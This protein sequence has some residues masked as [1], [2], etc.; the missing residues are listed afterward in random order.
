MAIENVGPGGVSRSGGV[1][2]PTPVNV[3]KDVAGVD[4]NGGI[5]YEDGEKVY[6]GDIP[7]YTTESSWRNMMGNTSFGRD[8]QGGAVQA[9]PKCVIP[10]YCDIPAGTKVVFGFFA[11]ASN[12]ETGSLNGATWQVGVQLAGE[13]ATFSPAYAIPEGTPVLSSTPYDGV[14]VTTTL[15]KTWSSSN[16]DG[17]FVWT[18]PADIKA[19]SFLEMY[20]WCKNG[21]MRTSSN[22]IEFKNRIPFGSYV[23]EGFAYDAN[24]ANYNN[25]TMALFT[26]GSI[27]GMTQSARES[28]TNSM[29]NG[30]AG[31]FSPAGRE[32]WHVAPSYMLVF[33]NK[34]APAALGNSKDQ[35]GGS[36]NATI[37]DQSYTYGYAGNLLG[38]K[39]PLMSLSAANDKFSDWVL[40]P[41]Y[42][43]VR[44]RALQYATHVHMCDWENDIGT[45]AGDTA[46]LSTNYDLF[47]ALPELQGKIFTTNT[48]PPIV[49]AAPANPPS[50]YGI[51]QGSMF[52]STAASRFWINNKILTD[53]RYVKVYDV[54]S[55]LSSRF[56]KNRLRIPR[57]ARSVVG[58]AAARGAFTVT[59]AVWDSTGGGQ[60][61]YTVSSDPTNVVFPNSYVEITGVT[62]SAFNVF[63][64]VK[65]VTS[66]TIV[67]EYFAASSIGTYTS[68]GSLVTFD[69]VITLT[70]GS[71]KESD[72]ALNIAS[73][74]MG[75]AASWLYREIY[76]VLSPTTAVIRVRNF[77]AIGAGEVFYIGGAYLTNWEGS[78]PSSYDTIHQSRAHTRYMDRHL[79]ERGLFNQ[80]RQY[81][82]PELI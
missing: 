35:K 38:R 66:T 37:Y 6:T 76:E 8:R 65:S 48:V 36:S 53:P 17:Q 61:T 11:R 51:T 26:D 18:V 12:I 25:N 19:G 59:N 23:G 15:T 20:I 81:P 54:N 42:N 31:T 82:L 13:G 67:V 74:N 33:N 75:G 21:F 57:N 62:P 49:N 80:T 72:V 79:G 27:T 78:F 2:T 40:N 34:A 69:I 60:I 70:K 30:N 16:A 4:S 46:T 45:Y 9:V 10:V 22:D 39:F 64:Q 28:L 50:D 52:P 24:A 7:E 1:R 29:M 14:P 71:F 43:A 32:Y 58:S 44:R 47:F 73:A 5:Y 63:A 41:S 56:S 77:T 55:L 68:G 3:I